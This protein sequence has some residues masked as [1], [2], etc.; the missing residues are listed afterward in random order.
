[1]M[2]IIII[3]ISTTEQTFLITLNLLS[4]HVIFS[5]GCNQLLILRRC[6]NRNVIIYLFIRFLHNGIKGTRSIWNIIPTPAIKEA[7]FV[8][9]CLRVRLSVSQPGELVEHPF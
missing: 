7:V 1:M 4:Y 5:I 8:V 3:F 2:Y 6:I 9:L